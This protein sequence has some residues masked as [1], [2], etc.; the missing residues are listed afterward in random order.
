M[1]WSRSG[2][3]SVETLVSISLHKDSKT[4]AFFLASLALGFGIT[5]CRA[6][7]NLSSLFRVVGYR[8]GIYVRLPRSLSVSLRGELWRHPI[9]I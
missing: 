7:N 5:L 9:T 1:D 6:S 8:R 3:W 2:S 4:K